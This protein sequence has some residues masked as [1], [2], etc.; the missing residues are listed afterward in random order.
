MI[1]PSNTSP[2]I[3]LNINKRI[4][5]TP[6]HI[7]VQHITSKF[8]DLNPTPPTPIAPPPPTLIAPPPYNHRPTHHQ[9]LLRPTPQQIRRTEV[10]EQT[11]SENPPAD[12]LSGSAPR[13]SARSHMSLLVPVATRD[14]L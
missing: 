14:L 6:F 12:S 2:S 7:I 1:K 4:Y 3:F 8:S 5:A 13:S 10:T 11:W 9:S